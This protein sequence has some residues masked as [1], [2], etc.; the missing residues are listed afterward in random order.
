MLTTHFSVYWIYLTQQ[1]A[2]MCTIIASPF[3]MMFIIIA[4]NLTGDFLN[5]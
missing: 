4:Y 2:G 3:P 5:H 1:K